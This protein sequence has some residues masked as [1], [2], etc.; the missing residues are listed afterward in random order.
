M[1]SRFG[2]NPALTPSEIRKDIETLRQAAK[3]ITPSTE[4]VGKSPNRISISQEE[5]LVE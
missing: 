5:T 4:F 3:V 2:V 1:L